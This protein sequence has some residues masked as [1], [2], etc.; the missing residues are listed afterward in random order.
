MPRISNRVIRQRLSRYNSVDLAALVRSGELSQNQLGIAKEILGSRGVNRLGEQMV[1]KIK[2][3]A[4]RAAATPRREKAPR[5]SL[6][7][8]IRGMVNQWRERVVAEVTEQINARF[9]LA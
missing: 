3:A 1:K 7:A 8:E 4:P 9:G 5:L 6:E 2:A